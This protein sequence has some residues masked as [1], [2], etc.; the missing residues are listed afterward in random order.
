MLPTISMEEWALHV[1]VTCSACTCYISACICYISAC[2]CYV[3]ACNMYMYGHV[4]CT[5]V[6]APSICVDNVLSYWLDQY[7]LHLFTLNS[8]NLL[9]VCLYN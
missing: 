5:N 4:I 6:M 9:D 8:I 1:H 2:I 7:I 3:G